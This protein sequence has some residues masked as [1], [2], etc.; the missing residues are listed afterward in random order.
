MTIIQ[1]TFK[2]SIIIG[3]SKIFMIFSAS[4]SDEGMPPLNNVWPA[5]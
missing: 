1:G 2:S 4:A 5:L 3:Y